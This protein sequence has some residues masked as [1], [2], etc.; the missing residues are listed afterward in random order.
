MSE[1]DAAASFEAALAAA[2]AAYPTQPPPPEAEPAVKEAVAVPA[3]DAAAAAT[4]AP[5][6]ADAPAAI[7]KY[8]LDRE[9][10]L[11]AREAKLR[12][13][14]A[15]TARQRV[16]FERNPVAYIKALNP[17][18][19]TA[20]IAEMLYYDALGT[21]APV[22][23]KMRQELSEVTSATEQ[24]LSEVKAQLAEMTAAKQAAEQQALIH[25]YKAELRSHIPDAT[26]F[27]ITHSLAT[28]NP[29]RYAEILFAEAHRA[30]NATEGKRVLSPAEAAQAAEAAL[31]KQRDELYGPPPPA[32]TVPAPKNAPVSLW[33]RDVA[34]QPAK[35]PPDA[36]DDN[37]LRKAA[38]EQIGASHLYW[39][40]K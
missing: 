23:H 1:P 30:A 27:P 12:T 25:G 2:N 38:L 34:R 37:A 8:I 10:A 3:V 18:A 4:A 36:S 21:A 33:N 39:E 7:P 28:R 31:T 5:A 24:S 11:E 17:K 9:A 40:N 35:V 20:Q 13:T 15:E 16:S 22:E 29:E 19:S 32:A 26:K 6:P 14:E